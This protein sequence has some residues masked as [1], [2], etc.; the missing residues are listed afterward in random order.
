MTSSHAWTFNLPCLALLLTALVYFWFVTSFSR[1]GKR[2]RRSTLKKAEH[3]EIYSPTRPKPKRERGKSPSAK[4]PKPKKVLVYSGVTD[5]NDLE[6]NLSFGWIGESFVDEPSKRRYYQSC[7]I[8]DFTVVNGDSVL[9]KLEGE[10][11]LL[12]SLEK[13]ILQT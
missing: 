1:S 8:D 9:L 5:E 6:G 7:R 11:S 2:Q 13:V 12:D 4:P 10:G 3:A